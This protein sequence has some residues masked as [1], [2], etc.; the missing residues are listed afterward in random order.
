MQ[1]KEFNFLIYSILIGNWNHALNIIESLKKEVDSNQLPILIDVQKAIIARKNDDYE[2]A[3]KLW[4]QIQINGKNLN[5]TMADF[6][7]VGYY[8]TIADSNE[9][10]EEKYYLKIEEYCRK[11]G[12]PILILISES[13]V[14][15][16]PNKMAILR[17]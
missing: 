2:T 15:K 6:A 9:K 3:K 11:I 7:K 10:L 14:S 12:D 4:K 8:D 16:K 13:S 17:K 1:S 5:D